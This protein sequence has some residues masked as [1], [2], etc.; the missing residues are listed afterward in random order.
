MHAF[1]ARS[2]LLLKDC[3]CEICLNTYSFE[4]SCVSRVCPGSPGVFLPVGS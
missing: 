3:E 2:N 1:G 4:V